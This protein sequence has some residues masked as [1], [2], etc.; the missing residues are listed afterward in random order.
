MTPGMVENCPTANRI[1]KVG[2]PHLWGAPGTLMRLSQRPAED[3]AHDLVG[4]A[5]DRPE[6]G[7][8][9]RPFELGVGADQAQALILEL[10]VGALG[11]ELGHRDLA[12]GVAA[13]EVAAQRVVGERGA[14]LRAGGQLGDAMARRLAAPGQL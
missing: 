8:A 2:Y 6:A 7:V 12:D 13:V 4:A 14:G 5:A 3:L 9:G 11:G 1:A 10:E